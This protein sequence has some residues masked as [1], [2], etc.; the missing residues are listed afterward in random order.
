[1]LKNL[2]ETLKERR[3]T[4]GDIVLMSGLT[5]T[6]QRDLHDAW[7]RAK[8]TIHMD[9]TTRECLHMVCHKLARFTVGDHEHRD[10]L[11]DVIGYSTR[12]A[13]YHDFQTHVEDDHEG[14]S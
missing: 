14:V 1:M 2:D 13:D 4:H 7:K 6:L 5:Q 12:L 9:D 8:P 11:D 3:S 10:H